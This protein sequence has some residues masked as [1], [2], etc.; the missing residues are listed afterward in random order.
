M[1]IEILRPQT[2]EEW[3]RLRQ[4]DVTASAAAA[5]L[6]AHPYTT[7]Y[8]LWA[9]KTGRT[10]EDP[11]ETPIFRR[12]RLLEP[13]NAQMLI[14]DYPDWRVEY[15]LKSAYYRDAEKR[16]GATPDCFAS[17]PDRPGFGVVQFK[18]ASD[19]VFKE[20][21]LD[22]ETGAVVVPLWIAC[23]AIVEAA[24]TGASWACVSVVVVGFGI[25]LHVIDIPLHEG[26]LRRIEDGVADFWRVVNSGDHPPIDWQRDGGTVLDVFRQSEAAVADLSSE[27][28]LD[29]LVDAYNRA[30][31]ARDEH[32]RVV[33]ALRPQLLYALGSNERGC[34]KRHLIAAPT[35]V[36]K[37]FAVQETTS[38]VLKIKPVENLHV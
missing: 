23:Q 36:R 16:I 22:P 14:E 34:T 38:R 28:G 24:Q 4:G 27:T 31:T 3:L 26:V 5:V 33:K 7:Q 30:K 32:D 18:S 37:A 9:L 29:D 1:T 2:R 6:G 8:A 12:G 17:R 35:G 15:P 21:W 25:E 10:S 20:K 13:V 11:E 19:L